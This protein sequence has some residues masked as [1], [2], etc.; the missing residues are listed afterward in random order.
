MNAPTRTPENPQARASDPAASAWV[1]ANAGSGKTHVLVNRVIRLLLS[2]VEP[3]RILCL[4]FTK[5]AAAEMNRRLFTEL[6]KWVTLADRELD[7]RI[8]GIGGGAAT[9]ELRERARRLFTLSLE[10][11]GGLKIQTLHAFS[12]RLLQLFPVE[13]GLVPGFEIMDERTAAEM[14]AA[15]RHSVF[16]EA[17][18]HPD[19]ELGVALES[20]PPWRR[21][22]S[23]ASCR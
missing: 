5:A 22:T 9:S 6:S 20:L 8:T 1:S 4:T 10:T 17:R 3:S 21:P 2:G 12:E 18:A 16:A 14:M 19:D 15:A 11:P 7:E 23:S 13:A